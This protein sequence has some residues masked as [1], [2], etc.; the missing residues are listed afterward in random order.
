MILALTIV[1]WRMLERPP[2]VDAERL[3]F[4]TVERAE[5]IHSVAAAGT[6][7]APRIRAVTNR[8]AGIVEAIH[9][10][11]GD[12]VDPD[13]IVLQMSSPD[14]LE[15]L[16]QARW[17]LTATEAEEAVKQV[18][19]EDRQLDLT[20]Q[21]AQAEADYMSARLEL[22]AQEELRD[23]QVFSEL[24]LERSRLKVEQLRHR[25]DAERAR[26]A[27][28][29]DHRRAQES[30]IQARLARQREQVEHLQTLVAQL[31][32]R[33]GSAGLVQEVNVEE[34]EQLSAGELI[35][36]IVDA[37]HLIARLN[38]PER[39]AA[40]L[41]PG[42]RAALQVGN[43]SLLGFV[44]RVDP[45]AS[46]R[47]VTVDVELDAEIPATLRPDL[48]VTGQIELERISAVMQIPRP[49]A[50]RADDQTLTLFIV[51]A[52]G[53]QAERR[54]VHFGRLAVDASEVRAGLEPG[55]RV[56]LTDLS[57]FV[58]F[59]TIRIE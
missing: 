48:S 40:R 20:A 37:N 6:L 18:E 57:D 43:E 59:E 52:E 49:A 50:A 8:N 36:R 7:V 23:A 31:D 2:A 25:L 45:T 11:P 19:V 17:D 56:I 22:E 58:E 32:V 39:E 9:V 46:D 44:S 42:L 26:M 54:E 38:V 41:A 34:G 10:L 16:T 4:G 1:A 47:Q 33:A 12:K 28:A 55:E 29:P 30:A 13:T 53:T 5:M 27:R 24:E 35:A 3:W 21:L 15:D 14:L 51:N